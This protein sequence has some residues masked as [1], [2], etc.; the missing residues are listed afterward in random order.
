MNVSLL[1]NEQ[2]AKL[3][4]LVKRSHVGS[5][6]YI[7]ST[8]KKVINSLGGIQYHIKHRHIL[9]KLKNE[10]MWVSQRVNE[11][12]RMK[13]EGGMIKFEWHCHV[14]KDV[15]YSSHQSLRAHLKKHYGKLFNVENDKEF[16]ELL[17][18][19]LGTSS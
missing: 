11:G 16:T 8:C 3:E 15:V 14:C 13:N 5:K 1:T 2:K 6:K 12:K 4:E 18:T 19:S 17:L 10:T 7:C 9:K